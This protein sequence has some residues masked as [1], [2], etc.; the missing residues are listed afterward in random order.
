MQSWEVLAADTGQG[1]ASSH[2]RR[3]ATWLPEGRHSAELMRMSG[4]EIKL[5]RPGRAPCY[6]IA[7]NTGPWCMHSGMATEIG[8]ARAGT[9]C[10]AIQSVPLD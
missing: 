10:R 4:S 5:H 9:A 2:T 1:P 3:A 8:E 7:A 6:C